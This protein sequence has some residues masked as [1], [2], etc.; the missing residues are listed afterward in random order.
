MGAAL[1][2]LSERVLAIER[3]S[4]LYLTE[5]VGGPPQDWYVNQV[6]AG[7]TSLS[8]EDLLE[9]CLAIEREH[10]R[11][12]S[13]RNAPRTL[14]LDVLFLGDERIDT[15]RLT[16]PHPRLQ[17]RRFVLVPL[18]EIAPELRHPVLGATI[19]ELLERCQDRSAVR[20]L[21]TAAS[22]S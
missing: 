5:P 20:V 14:D 7:S 2:A 21:A 13:V 18:A 9:A 8:A 16:L 17:E 4:R 22:R 15:P 3:R 1:S 19:A 11:E 12:R 6:V 10:G